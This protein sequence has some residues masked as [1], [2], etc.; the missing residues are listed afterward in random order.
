MPMS[1]IL[2]RLDRA[3][4]E[5]A[6]T[7]AVIDRGGERITTYAEIDD[8][9]G[10]VATYLIKKGI[11]TESVCVIDC[12][13]GLEFIAVRIG[14]I[15]AGA[16]WVGIEQMMGSERIDYIT[17]N[18]NAAMVFD[19]E[20]FNAAMSEEPLPHDKWIEAEPHDL[21]F[22]IYTS[23][24]TGTPKG[25]AQEYGI[26]DLILKGTVP[27]A[28]E[29]LPV[30][31]ANIIPE[32]YVGGVYIT[33]GALQYGVTVHELPLDAVRDPE[34]LLS[35]FEKNDINLTFMPP[36]LAKLLLDTG[37]LHLKVLHVGGEIV[38]GVYTDEF[39]VKNIYGPTEFG[40]PTCIFKLDR[41]YENTPIGTPVANTMIKLLNEDGIVNDKEG[42]LCVHL[43]WFRGY[44]NENNEENYCMIDGLKYFMTSDVARVEDGVYTILGRDDDMIKINGNRI[45]PNEAE[46]AIR[47]V[48]GASFVAVKSCSR[49][50]IKF[51]CAYLPEDVCEDSETLTKKLKDVIPG[52]MMPS[53]V[54]KIKALPLSENGKIDRKA[55]PAPKVQHIFYHYSEPVTDME[56][57]FCRIFEEVLDIETGKVGI[58]D[59]FFLMGGDSISAMSAVIKADIPGLT[60]KMIYQYETVRRLSQE[61]EKLGT[62]PEKDIS[63]STGIPLTEFQRYFLNLLLETPD[64]IIYNL[65]VIIVFRPEINDKK[66]IDAIKKAFK[67]HPGLSI[68][69]KKEEDEWRQFCD[70]S[71][72]PEIETCSVGEQE[73]EEIKRRFV[74]LPRFDGSPLYRICIARTKEKVV[75]MLDINHIICDGISLR[76]IIEDIIL[77]YNGGC[78][79]KDNYIDILKERLFLQDEQEQIEDRSFFYNRY[80]GNYEELPYTD[81]QKKGDMGTL[82]RTLNFSPED[83]ISAAKRLHISPSMLYMIASAMALSAYNETENV[84]V[85]W[86]F[87]GREDAK[88]QRAVGLLIYDF[89]IAFRFGE[90]KSIRAIA[91]EASLQVREILRHGD[92]SPFLEGRLNDSICF[93]YQGDLLRDIEDELIMDIDTI[94]VPSRVAIDLLGINIWEDEA[95]AQ[96]TMEY[97]AGLYYR[98]SMERYADLYEDAC[99]RLI[100]ENED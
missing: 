42:V 29:Y 16:A 9:S 98:S 92:V 26:Y 78:V 36:T 25:S 64:R 75:L 31:V 77:I 93:T 65:P 97:D 81:T 15:K 68:G 39:D 28:E 45:D 87:N 35:Y 34:Y 22:I 7:P 40:Y 91:D 50:G 24:S 60:V 27:M 17:R 100:R 90:L 54:M 41:A 49:G 3:M 37:R 18:C 38:S 85:H 48:T 55:L 20:H 99:M 76:N 33:V 53:C 79:K 82:E 73:L 52:Y 69:I 13:R 80:K 1:T 58:D 6:D 67:A 8:I 5:Y 63:L 88:S 43:P 86:T 2:D 57:K 84:R 59:N 95:G 74:R 51:L 19:M 66:L 62:P 30:K 21:A 72:E 61:V 94:E 70:T 11:G 32:T 46:A 96:L 83:V 12:P 56:K 47:K 23:G 14:V 4:M 44:L 10:R 71:T 89:P